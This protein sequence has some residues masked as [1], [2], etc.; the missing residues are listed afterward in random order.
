MTDKR[1]SALVPLLVACG[2]AAGCASAPGTGSVVRVSNVLN[3]GR[4]IDPTGYRHGPLTANRAIALLTES[5]LSGGAAAISTGTPSRAE[6][7]T[8]DLMAVEL[9]G[10]SGNKLSDDAEAFATAELSYH[11]Y[12]LIEAAYARPLDNDIAALERDCPDGMELDRQSR[13][14]A[15]G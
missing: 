14:V 3:C 9:M 15:D 8:L 13:N 4:V 2:L 7:S 11:P 1:A 5:Q 6:I 12:S 10:Y